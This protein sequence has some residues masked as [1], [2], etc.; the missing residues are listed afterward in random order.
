VTRPLLDVLEVLLQALDDGDELHGWAIMK[1]VQRSGPTVYGVLDRLEDAGW[2]TGRWEDQPVEPNR[3]RR[4]LYLLTPPGV[5]AARELLADR[6]S[7]A[8][9]RPLRPAPGMSLLGVLRAFIG[10]AR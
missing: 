7:A 4:R 8:A 2:V 9:H 10:T 6:R 1:R 3:P 5:R